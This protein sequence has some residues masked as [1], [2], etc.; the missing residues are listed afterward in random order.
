MFIIFADFLLIFSF[1]VPRAVHTYTHDRF[2]EGKFVNKCTTMNDAT[3][4]ICR[5]IAA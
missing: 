2:I 4:N 5:E 3:C 1:Y